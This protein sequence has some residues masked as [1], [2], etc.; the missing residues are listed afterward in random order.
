MQKKKKVAL[1][2]I[3]FVFKQQ[4]FIIQGCSDCLLQQTHQNQTE[5]TMWAHVEKSRQLWRIFE[6][7]FKKSQ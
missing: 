2:V 3:V 4:I 7:S 1:L 6:N 5:S